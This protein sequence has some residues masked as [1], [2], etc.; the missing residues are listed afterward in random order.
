MDALFV[1]LTIVF[2][3]AALIYVAGCARL[4]GGQ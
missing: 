1:L 3:A 2:F 4:G